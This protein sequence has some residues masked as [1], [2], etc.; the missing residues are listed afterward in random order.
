M[1][2]ESKT[3]FYPSNEARTEE[4]LKKFNRDAVL[5][6]LIG[7]SKPVI[8][9]V[10]GYTG[11]SIIY[12]K[13]LFPSA[14]ITSFEPNPLVIDAIKEVAAQFDDVKVVHSAVSNCTGTIEYVQQ[15]INPGLGSVHRRNLVSRDSIDLNKLCDKG[16][17]EKAAYLSEVNK[18]IVKVPATTLADYVVANPLSGRFCHSVSVS[19]ISPTS[20]R[21]P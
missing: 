3:N 12:L 5:M 13:S 6:S 7:D 14:S 2:K 11:T 4:Y 8:F 16:E 21:I 9:D 19:G 18:N 1:L 10:G 15:G 17:P 20:P